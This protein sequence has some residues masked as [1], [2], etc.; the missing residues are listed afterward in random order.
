VGNIEIARLF[1]LNIDG[2][3][4]QC[5]ITSQTTGF[6]C[7]TG[8]EAATGFIRLTDAIQDFIVTPVF[9]ADSDSVIKENIPQ[10]KIS[11]INKNP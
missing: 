9:Y 6:S 3:L 2:S 7:L 8:D 4:R 1:F 10:H 5:F 11:T